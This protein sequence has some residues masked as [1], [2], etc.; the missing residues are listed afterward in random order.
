MAT[1]MSMRKPSHSEDMLQQSH[2]SRMA[3]KAMNR[4]RRNQED[5]TM[6][7]RH[8]PSQMARKHSAVNR[9]KR[10]KTP[11]ISGQSLPVN[12]LIEVLDHASLSALLQTVMIH[13]PE[14]VQTVSKLAPKPSVNDTIELIKQKAN[15]VKANLPYRCDI[16]SDYSYIRVKAHLTEFLGCISDFVLDLLPPMESSLQNAC[17]IFDMI[18]T[19]IHELPN[20]TNKEFQYTKNMAYEQIANSWLTVLNHH[21]CT[22]EPESAGEDTSAAG[23][24]IEKSIEWLKTIEEMHLLEQ[25]EKHNEL[26]GTKFNSLVE[27]VRSELDSFA[28]INNSFSNTGSIF[29]DFITVDYSGFSIP[30]RTSH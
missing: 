7:Q 1:D 28:Q 11:T 21:K 27:F 9:F 22:E 19:M 13:H 4:K 23:P 18:T 6:P 29:Q 26:S 24:N 2:T 30:A 14:I 10:T 15:A 3:M 25:V 5:E 12:R 17:I 20:F 8:T 16:E